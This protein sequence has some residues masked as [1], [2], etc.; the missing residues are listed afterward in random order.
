VHTLFH[1][2]AFGEACVTSLLQML[3]LLLQLT[4]AI[5]LKLLGRTFTLPLSISHLQVKAHP[6]IIAKPLLSDYPFAG[7]LSMS[8]M[9]T[10]HVDFD[11]PVNVMGK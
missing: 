10:P 9:T 4:V 1:S 3:L 8:L 5:S 7:A 2:E 11:L 6:R